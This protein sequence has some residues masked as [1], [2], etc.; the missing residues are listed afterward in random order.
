MLAVRLHAYHNTHPLPYTNNI[1]V[2]RLAPP[3][4]HKYIYSLVMG[5]LEVITMDTYQSYLADVIVIM[6]IMS[7]RYA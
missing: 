5:I 2:S 7:R 4:T 3:Y 6:S 1:I